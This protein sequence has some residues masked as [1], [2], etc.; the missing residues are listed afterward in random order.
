M[1]KLNKKSLLLAI[2]LYSYIP[3]FIFLLGWV[4]LCIALPSCLVLLYF[5]YRFYQ[6]KQKDISDAINVHWSV[7]TILSILILIICI[8]CGYGGFVNQAS[9]WIKHNAI[10]QD[11][12]THTWPVTYTINN[13]TTLLTYYHGLYLPAALVGK[14]FSS[15]FVTELTFGIIGYIGFWLMTISLIYITRADKWYKQLGVFLLFVSFSGLM[16]PL[17]KICHLVTGGGYCKNWHALVFNDHMLQFRSIFVMLRWVGPQCFTVWLSLILFLLHK[18]DLQWYALIALPVLLSGTWAFL[19]LVVIMM[20]YAIYLIFKN[21]CRLK[22]LFSGSNILP[23]IT[24]GIIFFLYLLGNKV[25]Q[26]DS[27][28]NHSFGLIQYQGI[29]WIL[30]LLFV[31]G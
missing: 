4:K 3:L 16:F 19:G 18:D 27:T 26:G 15:H 12:Y 29:E 23:I 10:L 1:W 17:Q 2:L 6:E 11:L 21:P 25:V 7:L 9:D 30:Y 24:S 13:E 22:N 8:L 14:C 20:Y 5:L 31:A 28:D